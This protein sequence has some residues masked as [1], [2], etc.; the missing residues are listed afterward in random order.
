MG[1][2]RSA[3]SAELSRMKKD[4]LIM[5]HKSEFTLLEGGGLDA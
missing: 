1:V 2:D 5:Y 3:M 4:K